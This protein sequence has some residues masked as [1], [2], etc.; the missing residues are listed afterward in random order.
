MLY[1]L[2]IMY[3]VSVLC[4]VRTRYIMR[5]AHTRRCPYMRGYASKRSKCMFSR[6]TPLHHRN[7]IYKYPMCQNPIKSKRI[8]IRKFQNLLR[9]Q[10]L[11]RRQNIYL[12][13]N[14]DIFYLPPHKNL[15]PQERVRIFTSK[16]RL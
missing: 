15:A 1:Y 11:H 4:G 14:Y 10:I 12:Y 7:S 5:Y 9:R 3:Y 13:W 2:N 6:S 16:L 8:K